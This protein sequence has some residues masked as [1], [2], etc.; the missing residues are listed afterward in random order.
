MNSSKF[1]E[2]SNEYACASSSNAEEISDTESLATNPSTGEPKAV[3]GLPTEVQ[4]TSVPI[5]H[6]IYIIHAQDIAKD[7]ARGKTSSLLDEYYLRDSS[8]ETLSSN[9][10]RTQCYP[11]IGL[12]LDEAIKDLNDAYI[13][14]DGKL[15][16]DCL[17]AVHEAEKRQ[18]AVDART[19]GEEKRMMK[20]KYE[21]ELKDARAR[22]L[23]YAEREVLLE[24]GA[25][26]LEDSLS[27]GL[28]IKK[29][30]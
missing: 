23:M 28:P 20:E 9:K 2:V 26:A 3:E 1:T 29:K 17:V 25:L 6:G 7:D 8:R 22:K 21:K 14:K 24:K 4:D 16:L 13:T 27:K 11:F 5:T 18:A 15:V 10:V 30:Y 19:F 12:I